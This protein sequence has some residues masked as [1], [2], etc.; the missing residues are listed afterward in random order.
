MELKRA[1]LII[2]TPPVTPRNS[3]LLSVPH[4]A[5]PSSTSF[6]TPSMG[7]GGERM[8][9]LQE[10]L[11][12]GFELG[13]VRQ[14]ITE[15]D[16]GM[17]QHL[18]HEPATEFQS[19][20]SG[21]SSQ[22]SQ[23]LSQ[24]L[25][26]HSDGKAS[27]S[28]GGGAVELNTSTNSNTNNN[29]NNNTLVYY[30]D[31]MSSS[32]MMGGARA[33]SESFMSMEDILS[34]FDIGV[35]SAGLPPV[36]VYPSE[37]DDESRLTLLPSCDNSSTGGTMSSSLT[38]PPSS[39]LPLPMI[40]PSLSDHHHHHHRGGIVSSRDEASMNISVQHQRQHS[41]SFNS[42][43]NR[44]TLPG[45]LRKSQTLPKSVS[46]E[47]LSKKKKGKSG[48][49]KTKKGGSKKKKFAGSSDVLSRAKDM[50][51]KPPTGRPKKNKL[52][53]EPRGPFYGDDDSVEFCK[54]STLL[55]PPLS[56]NLSELT[57][58]HCDYEEEQVMVEERGIETLNLEP[59][60][61]DKEKSL[62]LADFIEPQLSPGSDDKSVW[63]EYG[64]I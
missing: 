59:H 38:R 13:D 12:R 39:H 58:I 22:L 17:E 40:V 51:Q 5:G 8:F 9:D 28:A 4:S 61:T 43:L 33:R 6:H 32:A 18:S 27:S 24:S 50:S 45:E 56:S 35:G 36:L 57:N 34:E 2:N 1:S 63:L 60:H 42:G 14:S 3:L 54:N 37:Q 26:Q 53:L 7:G 46:T 30:D 10:F 11:M 44:L 41:R 29:N 55:N 62:S 48:K 47:I 25:S 21:L 31:S 15:V 16:E 19:Q 52:L 23:G 49:D 64:Q 20:G